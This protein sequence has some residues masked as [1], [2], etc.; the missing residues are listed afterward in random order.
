MIFSKNHL[1]QV[2][3]RDGR[4]VPFDENRILNAI[5]KAMS[6]TGEG[7]RDDAEKVSEQVVA[8]AQSK[9][10]RRTYSDDRRDPGRRRDGTHRDGFREN[11]E[12]VHPLPQ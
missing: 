1:T 9:V 3:K 12:S 11:R 8:G 10:P 6:V 7:S 5:A 4:I 2:K